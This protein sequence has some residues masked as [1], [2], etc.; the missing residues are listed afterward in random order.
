MPLL[1]LL[2]FLVPMGAL[3]LITG[4]DRLEERLLPAPAQADPRAGLSAGNEGA[5]DTEQ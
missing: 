3:A 1:Y 2:V 5:P 4:L